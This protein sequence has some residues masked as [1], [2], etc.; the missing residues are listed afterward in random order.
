SPPLSTLP[1]SSSPILSSFFFFTHPLFLL[2]HPSS[3]P[4]TNLLVFQTLLLLS[5]LSFPSSSNPPLPLLAK[6]RKLQLCSCGR[7]GFLSSSSCNLFFF[8]LFRS[9]ETQEQAHLIIPRTARAPPLLLQFCV[10]SFRANN[11]YN[12]SGG[13][14]A[15]FPMKVTSTVS[16]EIS[17]VQKAMYQFSRD[18]FLL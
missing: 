15:M 16:S 8:F 5:F 17:V 4:S 12:P 3:P 14:S 10:F 7:R 13:S 1:S 6:A 9:K 2:L 18:L 11:L